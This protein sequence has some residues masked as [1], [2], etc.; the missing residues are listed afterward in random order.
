MKK[1]VL[2]ACLS[3][4]FTPAAHAANVGMAAAAVENLRGGYTTQP[5]LQMQNA[6]LPDTAE[7]P[8]DFSII[9]KDELQPFGASL[10]HGQ[11][12][13]D[14]R[15]SMNPD[16]KIQ[17]GDRISIG[18][19]GAEEINNTAIYEVDTSGNIFV[20]N[21][22]PISV[23]GLKYRDLNNVVTRRVRSLYQS[24]VQVYTQ[25]NTTQ[26]VSVFVTGAVT[27]PGSYAG[28]SSDS[29]LHYLDRANGVDLERGS[30]RRID[31]KRDEEIIRSIDL[32]EFLLS[33]DLPKLNLHHQDVIV[34]H[35]I[36]YNVSAEG[37]IRNPGMFEFNG[38]S[39]SGA[40][41]VRYTQPEPNVTHVLLQREQNGKRDATYY[42][43]AEFGSI[44][45]KAG[46]EVSFAART[47]A[48]SI[49]IHIEGEHL[50]D[51][52]MIVPKE[53]T[54]SKV[55]DRIKVD[56]KFS[57]HEAVYLK[58]ESVKK[59]QEEAL[60][61]S[62]RRLEDSVMQV[63]ST[64][65]SEANLRFQEVQMLQEFIKRARLIEPEGRVILN[66]ANKDSL[67]LEH[68]DV[69]VIPERNDLILVSGEV[70]MP[71]A[72]LFDPDE[73]VDYYI[74]TA[75]GFNSRADEGEILIH[76]ANGALI[77]DY[78]VDLEPGD[79]LI[80]LP[81]VSLNDLQVAK[82]VADILYKIAIAAAVPFSL[83]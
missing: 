16:Y 53:A 31:V 39:L 67:R 52:V 51:E 66:E 70:L 9:N 71:R 12:A 8:Q 19:W 13:A 45:L 4:C 7:M 17:S 43:L 46:D 10:F 72:V 6:A 77:R 47:L 68:G 49:T 76:R 40:E 62:L 24:S 57:H 20:P 14:Q 18:L 50:G 34:V 1:L 2:A 81:E 32:Y 48:D 54:L 27:N 55:L 3:F 28:S 21:V 5:Q 30:F 56:P 58:R 78:Y 38:E 37:A 83:D 64:T 82:D 42:T 35:P 23:S 73:D 63:N 74:E 25:L 61:A 36:G 11:F 75:G 33:G 65:E 26:P 59:R 29:V 44:T 15:L 22:G 79:E 60:D 41:L 69:I 80:V